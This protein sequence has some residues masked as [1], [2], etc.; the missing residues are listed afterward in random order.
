[1]M[2]RIFSEIFGTDDR[3]QK[4]ITSDANSDE[5]NKSKEDKSTMSQLY[6]MFAHYS[7]KEYL[8]SDRIAP[9]HMKQ[10]HIEEMTCLMSIAERCIAYLLHAGSTLSEPLL[11]PYNRS[12]DEEVISKNSNGS[13]DDSNGNSNGGGYGNHIVSSIHVNPF[14]MNAFNKFPFLRYAAA[15]WTKHVQI[16]RDDIIGS[17]LEKLAL[18]F[19]K[20]NTPA[21]DM[22]LILRNTLFSS[23]AVTANDLC[24]EVNVASGAQDE[25]AWTKRVAVVHPLTWTSYQCLFGLVPSILASVTS[26]IDEISHDSKLGNPLFAAAL[27]NNE[28]SHQ[29]VESLL[30]NSMSPNFRNNGS[31]WRYAITRP[32]VDGDVKTCKLLVE[33]GANIKAKLPYGTPLMTAALFA[34]LEVCKYLI[35]KNANIEAVSPKGT[36]LVNAAPNG[37]L[38]VCKY[39][40]SEGASIEAAS[41]F[42]T[43]MIIAASFGRLEICKYPI[44]EDVNVNSIVSL[45]GSETT[46][47][48]TAANSILEN[49]PAICVCLLEAGATIDLELGGWTPLHRA[50]KKDLAQTCGLLLEWGADPNYATTYKDETWTPLH[51]AC[52]GSGGSFEDLVDSNTLSLLFEAGADPKAL[53]GPWWEEGPKVPPVVTV[54]E[55]SWYRAERGL[56]LMK[57]GINLLLFS[58]GYTYK[59]TVPLLQILADRK[60]M[61]IKRREEMLVVEEYIN[62]TLR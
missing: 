22:F 43:P 38:E 16:I 25:Y 62:S 14:F 59:D 17:R 50:C 60:T 15:C 6:I 30:R 27:S 28:E 56:V 24:M 11:I 39:L 49:S 8:Q 4:S 51:R 42:G 41:N 33:A 26:N 5:Y 37:H 12:D 23:D 1:M 9:G 53:G 7:V 29:I 52:S 40:V 31:L 2:D 10:Y 13:D 18:N 58:T 47:L 32:C 61:L 54:L 35:S 36:P 19:L 20:E 55:Y 45:G 48:H 57:E 34:Q 44:G 46:A 3:D 21:W